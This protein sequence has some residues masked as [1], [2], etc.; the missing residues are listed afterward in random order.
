MNSW[1]THSLERHASRHLLVGFL[2]I[3][4]LLSI[5]PEDAEASYWIKVW[6]TGQAKEASKV[7]TTIDEHW[8]RGGRLT[9]VLVRKTQGAGVKTTRFK[10]YV[11]VY[12]DIPQAVKVA[13]HVLRTQPWKASGVFCPSL[14]LIATGSFQPAYTRFTSGLA[15]A[16]KSDEKQRYPY[17]GEA[18]TATGFGFPH[19]S[20]SIPDLVKSTAQIK[21]WQRVL[22]LGEK[23]ACQKTRRLKGGPPPRRPGQRGPSGPPQVHEEGRR[24]QRWLYAMTESP[25]ALAWFP[26]AHIAEGGGYKKARATSRWG[27]VNYRYQLNAIGESPGGI[28][29][30]AV[31][32]T[33]AFAPILKR[34]VVSKRFPKPHKLVHDK[35]G[36]AIYEGKGRV[37]KRLTVKPPPP[38][39]SPL[40]KKKKRKTTVHIYKP[41]RGKKK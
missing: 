28:I 39:L 37:V 22:V 11:G 25:L 26:A 8:T 34:L 14:Q 4:T 3:L 19:P 17:I 10:V 33:G 36:F 40:W 2:L 7:A 24:C 1:T 20:A 15:A 16:L 31:F 12:G 27:P 32:R 35:V 38:R 41:P 9:Q 30:H 13:I 18:V 5:S 6:E 23:S 29:Y 21:A